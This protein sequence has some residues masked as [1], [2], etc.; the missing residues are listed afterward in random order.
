MN[1]P[2]CACPRAQQPAKPGQPRQAPKPSSLVALLR[3]GT[4]ALRFTEKTQ[5][6]HPLK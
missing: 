2:E 3:P 5:R 1:R 4:G 6:N